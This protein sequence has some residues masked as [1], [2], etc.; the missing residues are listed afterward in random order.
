[1][2]LDSIAVSNSLILFDPFF[3]KINFFS[4]N[5]KRI[6]VV[7]LLFFNTYIFNNLVIN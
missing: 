6:L 2:S 1:M 7:D 3:Q 4:K 5:E